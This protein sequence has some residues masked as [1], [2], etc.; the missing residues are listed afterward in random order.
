MTLKS[1]L[2]KVLANEQI[3]KPYMITHRN[4]KH[5]I[6]CHQRGAGY[7]KTKYFMDVVKTNSQ[8]IQ[9]SKLRSEYRTTFNT[10]MPDLKGV[11][12]GLNNEKLQFARCLS[13]Q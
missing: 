10:P 8:A 7:S 2:M 9:A 5:K 3:S 13:T 4:G 1:N 11:R 6:K 12:S